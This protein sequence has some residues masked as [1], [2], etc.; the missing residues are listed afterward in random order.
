SFIQSV[1]NIVTDQENLSCRL[2]HIQEGQLIQ[3]LPTI[4][5]Y[6]SFYSTSS[7]VHSCIADRVFHDLIPL[8]ILNKEGFFPSV[9]T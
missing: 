8:I 4:F 3:I 6:S 5:S 7:T 9:L 2:L 1:C